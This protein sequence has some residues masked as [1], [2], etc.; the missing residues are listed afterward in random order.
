MS[1]QP[2][3]FLTNV[4]LFRAVAIVLVVGTHV[5]FE[6]HWPV[7]LA[8]EFKICLSLAQNGTVPFVFVAGLLFQYRL[9]HFSYAKYLKTKLS[10][11]VT[12]YLL[13]SL[14]FVWIQYQG[15]FGCFAPDRAMYGDNVWLH[16]ALMYLTGAQMVV[17]LWFVPMIGVVYLL[18]PAFVFLDRHPSSYWLLPPLLALASFAHR[19]EIQNHLGHSILYFVPVYLAGMWVGRYRVPVLSAA[20]RYRVGLLCLIAAATAFEVFTRQRPGAIESL[21]PF[22]TERG[23]FDVNLYQKL[24]FSV[25]ALE[26]LQGVGPR[27]ARLLDPVADVSFGIFF[28]HYYLLFLGRH[29]LKVFGA[30]AWTGSAATLITL[31]AIVVGIC[32]A[33]ALGLQRVMG[34]R[35]RYLIGC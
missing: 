20:R 17:P 1:P 2:L 31:S 33:L 13:I 9:Q 14:P 3:T 27:L 4:H 29:L 11:V 7:E 23:V 12:P 22:S 8:W 34:R 10:Y 35:S 19:P 6:M 30:G 5:L 28:T 25:V 32:T 18:S 26:L 16:T 15:R 24:A 21:A